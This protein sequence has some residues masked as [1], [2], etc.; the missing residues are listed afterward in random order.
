MIG[1][2][3]G[4]LGQRTDKRIVELLVRTEL[5]RVRGR[6][7]SVAERPRGATTDGEAV[8]AVATDAIGTRIALGH[9]LLQT[10]P[11]D[12]EDA[13]RFMRA[14]APIE[15]DPTLRL[16]GSELMVVVQPG[17]IP[18]GIDWDRVPGVVAGYLRGVLVRLPEGW[19]R[20]A[21][22][23]GTASVTIDIERTDVGAA[24]GGGLVVSRCTPQIPLTHSVRIALARKLPKLIVAPA[25]ERVLILEKAM[26]PHGYAQIHDAL[27]NVRPDYPLLDAVS[28]VWVANTVAWETEDV[29]WFRRVWPQVE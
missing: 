17:A 14:I 7:L 24:L 8:E 25:D 10:F 6:P 5:S 1:R 26:P 22:P 20:H 13:A 15:H 23:L 2:V 16:R 9:T 19:S 28:D 11:G 3:A 18:M 29:M 27:A 4:G 21:I 12:R